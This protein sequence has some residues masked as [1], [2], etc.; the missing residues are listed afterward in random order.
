MCVRFHVISLLDNAQLGVTLKNGHAS[1]AFAEPAGSSAA[2]RPAY[3]ACQQQNIRH[4]LQP[5]ESSAIANGR[6]ASLSSTSTEPTD[7]SRP[8]L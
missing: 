7:K 1:I 8:A 3:I 6:A 5:A 4:V 2:R